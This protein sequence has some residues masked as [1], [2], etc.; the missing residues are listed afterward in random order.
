MLR[1]AL[2]LLG[3]AGLGC[4]SACA[5]APPPAYTLQSISSEEGHVWVAIIE[6]RGQPGS[7][8]FLI[9]RCPEHEGRVESDCVWSRLRLPPEQ[10]EN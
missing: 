1:R 8:R 3:L 6:S 10:S 9:G 7:A 4:L 2:A 5:A